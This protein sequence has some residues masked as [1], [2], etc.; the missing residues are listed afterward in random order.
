MSTQE[1]LKDLEHDTNDCRC[2]KIED[3]IR[4]MALQAYSKI[5]RTD[6]SPAS[7]SQ[8][9]N[10]ITETNLH[11]YES[12][13]FLCG[14]KCLCKYGRTLEEVYNGSVVFRLHC[15]NIDALV[16]L[17]QEYKSGKLLQQLQKHFVTEELKR[18]FGCDAIKLSVLISKEDYY[19]CKTEL[20]LYMYMI[21]HCSSQMGLNASVIHCISC[22]NFYKC[23]R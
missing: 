6:S 22:V 19:T 2:S 7:F 13:Q 3:A 17:W 16:D 12:M 21:G 8:F 5:R 18:D 11:V 15:P 1:M 20:G 4:Q 10:E 9:Q 14:V 23:H